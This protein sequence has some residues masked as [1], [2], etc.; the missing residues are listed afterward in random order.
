MLYKYAVSQTFAI[1]QSTAVQFGSLHCAAILMR[2]D[3]RYSDIEGRPR[4]KLYTWGRGFYGQLGAHRFGQQAAC[5]PNPHSVCLGYSCFD[6]RSMRLKHCAL[7]HTDECEVI[8]VHRC[9]DNF[10]LKHALHNMLLCA[11]LLMQAEQ[12]EEIMPVSVTC[13]HN[14]TAVITRRGDLIAWGMGTSGQTGH[15]PIT[16][17]VRCLQVQLLAA[18]VPKLCIQPC[19][20]NVCPLATCKDVCDSII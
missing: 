17:D 3:D 11:A 1:A 19:L 12:E 10:K 5:V 15:G 20:D 6:V 2:K 14:H 7:R 9:I 16:G 4:Y 8:C 13:G 18:H